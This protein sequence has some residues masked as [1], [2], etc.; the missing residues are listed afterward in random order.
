VIHFS[1]SLEWHDFEAGPYLFHYNAAP[2][3]ENSY[4]GQTV[5]INIVKG[6]PGNNNNIILGS[7]IFP[8]EFIKSK[9]ND[10]ASI[11]GKICQNS[12]ITGN[13]K[14][15]PFLQH[16]AIMHLLRKLPPEK[17][18]S[19]EAGRDQKGAVRNCQLD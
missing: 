13:I 18:C 10:L 7:R 2:K 17:I 19:S 11:P 9:L 3:N 14:Q 1:E 4:K 8:L 15:S 6:S 12:G 5:S 16:K